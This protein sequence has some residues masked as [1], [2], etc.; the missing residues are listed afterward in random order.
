MTESNFWKEFFAQ[1]ELAFLA[2]LLFSICFFGAIYCAVLC[3]KKPYREFQ[4]E[5]HTTGDVVEVYETNLARL[6]KIGNDVE[7]VCYR[8]GNETIFR[9]N[10]TCRK[11]QL[12]E[13][14]GEVKVGKWSLDTTNATR[15]T[16]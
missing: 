11:S 1:K 14:E 4:V 8:D 15:S 12:P 7:A 3:C 9:A 16:P 5:I 2:I 10:I 6:K 13:L